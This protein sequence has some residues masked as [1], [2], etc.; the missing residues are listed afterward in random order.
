MVAME[1]QSIGDLSFF[2]GKCIS[3]CITDKSCVDFGTKAVCNNISATKIHDGAEIIGPLRCNDIG[4]ICYPTIV[5]LL[6]D[7]LAIQQIFIA[8]ATLFI[9]RIGASAPDLR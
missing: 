7:E 5:H 2:L 1:Q 6:L 9:Q 3:N 4:N 8:M